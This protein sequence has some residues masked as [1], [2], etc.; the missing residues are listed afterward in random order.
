MSTT[1]IS[2]RL[3]SPR[4]LNSLKP[5]SSHKFPIS[6][7]IF[8]SKNL[9]KL[10]FVEK[11]KIW[12]KRIMQE[13]MRSPVVGNVADDLEGLEIMEEEGFLSNGSMVVQSHFLSNGLEYTIN[14][15]SKW[16]VAALFGALILWKRDA[17]AL[18][19]SMGCVMNSGL[20]IILKKILNQERPVSTL[21]SDPGM[22]SSH[23]QS[24]FF[25]VFF[26]ILS[27]V[28]H[29][30]LNEIT[31]IGGVLIFAAGSYLSWLRVSQKLHTISQV[32]VGGIVGSIFSVLWFQA[33][34]ALVLQAFIASLWV[35]IIV[36]LGSVG[37]CVFFLLYLIKHWLVEEL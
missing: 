22:P 14:K 8:F 17:E 28:K 10:A 27:M 13:N 16:L 35:R 5:I 1:A 21:R 18:W 36:V 6:E 20:S 7:T 31:L 11:N 26:V 3:L 25:G 30:G 9:N 33:W 24:I 19:V 23:A 32:L 4:L 37:F 15:T 12:G 34:Y 29:L 2:Y